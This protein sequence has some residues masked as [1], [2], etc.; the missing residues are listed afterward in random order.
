MTPALQH[1]DVKD[2]AL[3]SDQMLCFEQ[4]PVAI[5]DFGRV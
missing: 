4:P 3:L 2:H 1:S 5:A